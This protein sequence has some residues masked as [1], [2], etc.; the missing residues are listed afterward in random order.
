MK[1]QD[2]IA[3]AL[4]QPH[5]PWLRDARRASGAVEGE[6]RRTAALHL[7]RH[8]QQRLHA[9]ARRRPARRSV[10]EALDD[11]RDPLAVEVL[12][13]DDDDAAAAE[14]EGGGQDAAVPERH[15]RLAARG[16]DR[17]EVLEPLDAPA[18]RVA[19][20]R[21]HWVADAGNRGRL[22]ALPWRLLPAF[23]HKG[24]FGTWDFPRLL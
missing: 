22:R 17:V 23:S 9:P 16:D 19:E 7:A 8:L 4:R 14:V 21:D 11:A 5:G 18:Q 2:R 24:G 20:R 6:A 10:A 1:R 13:G 3:G 12:A 15:D